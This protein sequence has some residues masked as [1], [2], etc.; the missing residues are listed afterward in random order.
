[1]TAPQPTEV[2]ELSLRIIPVENR[3]DRAHVDESLRV[4]AHVIERSRGERLT[5][6]GPQRVTDDERGE[7]LDDLQRFERAESRIA[8]NTEMHFEAFQRHGRR[9]RSAREQ[10]N[11]VGVPKKNRPRRLRLISFV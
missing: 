3:S 6:H 7:L 5:A 9:R 4:E 10:R 11:G 1:M 2:L 8:K